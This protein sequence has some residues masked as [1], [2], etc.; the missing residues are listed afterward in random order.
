MFK[1]GSILEVVTPASGVYTTLQEY[2]DFYQITDTAKD[3]YYTG[4]IETVSDMVTDYVD[5]PLQSEAVKETF[6]LAQA[7]RSIVLLRWPITVAPVVSF[8]SV[9]TAY[10]S[11]MYQTDTRKAILYNLNGDLIGSWA[12]GMWTIAYSGGFVTVPR[13]VKEAVWRAV[14]LADELQKVNSLVKAE[15]IEGIASRSYWDT[16]VMGD[17]LPSVSKNLLRRYRDR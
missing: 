14:R 7:V 15:R 5:R 8:S 2:K 10:S 1:N 13:A 12:P 11:T 3:T 16:S 4:L 6:R 17:S 9:L